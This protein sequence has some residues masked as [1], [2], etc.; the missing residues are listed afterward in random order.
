MKTIVVNLFGGP[1]VGKST[2]AASVFSD[3]KDRGF[4]CVLV[5][6]FAKDL[7]WAERD[8]ELNDQL[9]V[10]AEQNHRILVLGGKVNVVINDSPVLLSAIYTNKE[11]VAL[12]ARYAF[13]THNNMNFL[14]KRVREYDGH[15]RMQTKEQAL[16]KDKEM[17]DLLN[18][19]H[20][21]YKEVPGNE[22]GAKKIVSEVMKNKDLLWGC[23]DW[24]EQ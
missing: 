22:H 20:Y 4:N 16:E 23:S 6:E 5:Q 15:G 24:K 3:L 10:L 2:L 12:T 18:I 11:Y 7:V 9:Y 19:N 14:L 1:G 8:F 17:K 13:D 21:I